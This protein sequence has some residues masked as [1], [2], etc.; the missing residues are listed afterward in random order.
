MAFTFLC[1]CGVK[2]VYLKKPPMGLRL[3]W[4]L[5]LALAFGLGAQPVS[6]YD[7]VFFKE[8]RELGLLLSSNP[9]AGVKRVR[10]LVADAASKPL[11]LSRYQAVGMAHTLWGAYLARLGKSDSAEMVQRICLGLYRSENDTLR[12]SSIY[13]NLGIAAMRKGYLY[14]TQQYVDSALSC[15][16]ILNLYDKPVRA[17]ALQM[18][19]Y[20]NGGE[21]EKTLMLHRKARPMLLRLM[22]QELDAA[23]QKN[24]RELEVGYFNAMGNAWSG[25]RQEDSA[26]VYFAQ[27]YRLIEAEQLQSIKLQIGANYCKSAATL[28]KFDLANRLLESLLPESDSS[29]HHTHFTLVAAKAEVLNKQQKTEEALALMA[30]IMAQLKPDDLPDLY[31]DMYEV[32]SELC[33]S[34]KQFEASLYYKN[35]A[36]SVR[37]F[38]LDER[39]RLLGE[40]LSQ[41][42]ELREK[43]LN[44]KFLEETQLLKDDLIEKTNQRNRLYL[45]LALAL[46]VAVALAL[47]AWRITLERNRKT[48]ELNGALSE[49]LNFQN[50]LSTVLTH[51]IRNY[52]AAVD[53][54]PKIIAHH[55]GAGRYDEAKTMLQAMALQLHQ[56]HLSVNNLM[57]WAV[58]QMRSGAFGTLES[59]NA[60]KLIEQ[61]VE[62]VNDLGLSAGILIKTEVQV[63]ESLVLH[64][65]AFEVVLRNMLFNALKHSKAQNLNIKATLSEKRLNLVIIDDGIGLDE[66]AVESF[67]MGSQ[68]LANHWKNT[69]GGFGLWIMKLYCEKADAQISYTRLGETSQFVFQFPLSE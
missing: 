67:G 15:Y 33:Q 25:L 63:P 37:L 29:N 44:I 13:Y 30:G 21:Y 40:E 14:T 20:N 4:L 35:K 7:S 26:F 6:V 16:Q 55:L 49:A 48:Q 2:P 57:L 11:S 65:T 9:Q 54:A 62:A 43:D 31:G 47:Y 10:Q 23:T 28:G 42:F 66:R 18:A 58:P 27:A 36:D 68:E 51:D 50:A 3:L 61:Q 45:I 5:L 60:A 46:A 34:A 17:Y 52:S 12:M 8:Q 53:I 19:V 39:K 59:C 1:S 64:K 69:Q 56:L 32:Y 24:L 41:K 38:T 22:N